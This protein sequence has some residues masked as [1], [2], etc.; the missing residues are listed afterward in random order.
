MDN[1]IT[2][3]RVVDGSLRLSLPRCIS[4]SVIRID[5][6]EIQFIE[7]FELC[8][9]AKRTEIGFGTARLERLTRFL[10]LYDFRD[11][12]LAARALVYTL[13]ATG[14]IGID[15]DERHACAAFGATR[16]C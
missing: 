5:T 7:I 13:I 15:A 4:A 6:D 10:E 12:V 11:L 8:S 1:K 9:A 16:T 14:P 2:H 3:L